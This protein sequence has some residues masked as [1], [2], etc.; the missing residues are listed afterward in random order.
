MKIKPVLL[1]VLA[2]LGVTT[3]GPSD[4]QRSQLGEPVKPTEKQLPGDMFDAKKPAVREGTS[5]KKLPGDMFAPKKLPGDMF[6]PKKEKLPGE[7]F[8]PVQK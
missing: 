7:M 2:L 6:E 5:S 1:S 8:Q 3:S 4:A